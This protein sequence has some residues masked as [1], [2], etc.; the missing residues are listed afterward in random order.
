MDLKSAFTKENLSKFM[1]RGVVTPFLI[2]IG[3]SL[4]MLPIPAWLLDI[5]F[6]FNITLS[7]TINF[8]A[9]LLGV[10]GI[11]TP[12]VGALVHNGG[13]LLVVLNAALLYDR[14]FR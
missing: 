5:S 13:S 9:V 4:I 14:T 1:T 6:T 7:M 12:V 8:V 3:L 10:L 2:L 11:M